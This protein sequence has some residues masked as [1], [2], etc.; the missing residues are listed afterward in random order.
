MAPDV[1]NNG[2]AEFIDGLKAIRIPWRQATQERFALAVAASLGAIHEIHAPLIV[3]PH[4]AGFGKLVRG[5]RGVRA[6]G[7]SVAYGLDAQRLVYDGEVVPAAIALSHD[8]DLGRL[9]RAC[10][11]A[12]PAAAVVGD[13]SYDRLVAS[14]AH[15]AAYR[16]ALEVG[17]DQT[18][19]VVTST[20]G[21]RSLFGRA[22]ADLLPRL[23]DELP[24]RHFRVVML[25]H[26]NIWF[27]H[28]VWQVRTWLADC[29]R[30]GLG[31][32]PPEADWRAVLA[33][34]DLIIGDHGSA[35]L[36]GT[37]TG[38]PVVLASY[39]EGEVDP[40]SPQS[41]LA[42]VAPRLSPDVSLREQVAML[43]SER[44]GDRY[45]GVAERIT[46]AP[47]RFDRNMRGLMYR[48][49]RLRQPA[50]ITATPPAAAPFL[51]DRWAAHQAPHR[52]ARTPDGFPY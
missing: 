24:R 43:R 19:V 21:P 18:L 42:A 37:V 38:A 26:P 35:T 7:G 48:L 44:P 31:L 5:R 22:A 30:R 40:A 20:W 15:R 3:M 14:L 23:L 52:W 29:L 28:G 12:V 41:V 50:A 6:V 8:H 10:P 4:G 47:G 13:P 1:F 39:S 32:V 9:G 27:A 33:A 34:A 36:Y 2:V 17:A 11:E 25:L 45:S 49:L 51:L 46:S 16:R